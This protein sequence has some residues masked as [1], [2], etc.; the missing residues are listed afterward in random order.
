M[1][2]KWE[3]DLKRT[4]FAPFHPDPFMRCMRCGLDSIKRSDVR[5]GGLGECEGRKH[6]RESK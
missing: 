5:R 4:G 3:V 6:T 1:R 2:H